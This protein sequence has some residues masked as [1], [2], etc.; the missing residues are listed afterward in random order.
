MMC[1][2]CSYV[3]ETKC[4]CDAHIVRECPDWKKETSMDIGYACIQLIP[5]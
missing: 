4:L 3:F 5:H 2:L 1:A